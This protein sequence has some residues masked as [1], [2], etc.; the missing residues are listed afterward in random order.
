MKILW[1]TNIV[2]PEAERQLTGSGDLKSSGGWMLGAAD[3]LLESGNNILLTVATV[4][5]KVKELTKLQGEKITYYLLPY[6]RGNQK[7]NP[8]YEPFWKI[9]KQD[10]HPDVVHIHGTE[11]SHGLAYVD[12]CGADNVVVSI[13]GMK[14]AYYYYYYYGLTRWE[15]IKNITFRDLLRGSPIRGRKNFEK[16][17]A[18]EIELLRKV[19][20]IIGRTSWDR[21]LTWAINPEAQY[22]FCNE[23]LRNE[24]YDGVRWNYNA[25]RKHSIFLSQA[26][27]P[28]KGLHQVLKAIKLVWR[29]YPDTI[30][31]I[32]GHDITKDKT[33]R[34]KI[35]FTTYGKI[36]LKMIKKLNVTNAV[37]FTGN[38][39]ASEM[40][41]E[42]LN[43]NVFVCPSTIENSPNSLGEAQILGVPC[44]ASYVGG[45][46]DMMKG[47]ED[48]LYRFEEV[49]ML[50]LKI[51]EVFSMQNV[52]N[53]TA[54][55]LAEERHNKD[56]NSSALLGIYKIITQIER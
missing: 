43:C 52:K 53:D 28:I 47:D 5:S 30:I 18:Y 2:F 42:Y 56:R 24:F 4:S 8:E 29:E 48:H 20:H 17:S 55:F 23:T 45:I 54:R 9:V 31:R 12:A 34:E 14:S 40:K 35:H 13:Q 27:Y 32:A 44:I 22:H 26:G 37:T 16:Q 36:I 39:N 6:G 33:I 41:R 3:A 7:R 38:L 21:A 11:Y 1:I 15:I 10:V 46:P 25:C 49:E 51:C 19:K 50:A